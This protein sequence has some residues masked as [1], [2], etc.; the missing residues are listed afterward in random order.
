MSNKKQIRRLFRDA[1]FLRDKFTCKLCGLKS[2]PFCSEGDLDAHHI[3]PREKMPNGGYVKENGITLCKDNCHL[4]V[5]KY[6]NGEEN[7]VKYSPLKLYET[8]NSSY[9]TAIVESYNLK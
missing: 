5:E 1:C 6:L 3:I 9:E 2:S 8:I 4:M 7:D